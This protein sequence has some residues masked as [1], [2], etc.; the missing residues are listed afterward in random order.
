M[1]PDTRNPEVPE[2][3]VRRRHGIQLIWI[4][5]LVAA[6]IGA[7][8][9]YEAIQERGPSISIT[10]ETADG[11]EGGKTKIRYKDVEIGEVS[12]VRLSADLDRVVVTAQLS[13]GSDPY[14][15]EGTRFWVVRPRIGAGGISGLNTL[16]SGAY[17][18]MDVSTKGAPTR[19]FTG[20]EV[21]PAR[22]ADSEGLRIKLHAKSLGSIDVGTPVTHLDIEMGDVEGYRYLR[23]EERIEFDVYIEPQ[24]ADL[25]R[26][27]T[28]FWNASGVNVSLGTGGFDVQVESLEALLLGGIAFGKAPGEPLG[29]PARDGDRF[30][31]IPRESEA[32]LF[33]TDPERVVSYFHEPV[34][35]LEA[36]AAVE[37]RGIEI[38]RVLSVGVEMIP[39][40]VT[41]R[42][43]VVYEIFPARL[44]IE[45]DG[46]ESESRCQRLVELGLRSQ[47]GNPS[48]ITG[49][50]HLTVRFSPDTSGE[51]VGGDSGLTEV[52]T[53]PS[54]SVAVEEMLAELPGIVADLRD[55]IA[56]I[57][58]LVN[59]EDAQAT[60]AALRAAS[61][62]LSEIAAGLQGEDGP[63]F[64]T[65]TDVR[66]VTED[67]R[68]L[69][70]E[71][72]RDTPQLMDTLQETADAALGLVQD[73]GEGVGTLA[74]GM[75]RL[76]AELSAALREIASGMRSIA[77]LAEFLERHP[78][79]LLKG[80]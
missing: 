35:G 39:A 61:E 54:R 27:N 74:A 19:F 23:E 56:G 6:A 28:R 45:S 51:L 5:P 52:P 69:V 9:W 31:L 80:K 32:L 68:T 53:I 40:T 36:G 8:L 38:G 60:L 64:G 55:S 78:E 22:P 26:Q 75:P 44:A 49:A 66:A 41:F 50:R 25:V 14:L 2:A 18:G 76:E 42:M 58:T 33:G 73:G 63:M 62:S 72:R 34:D 30:R 7:W 43:P 12:S 67:L 70:A 46:A 3:L 37:F 13:A 57:S 47:L 1:S 4:V 48:L 21:P 10:F 16:V 29:P 11:L 71:V 79:A 77:A 20:L 15:V 24:F 65:L 59:D 17:I